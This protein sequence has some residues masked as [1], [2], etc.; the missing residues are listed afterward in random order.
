MGEIGT[1]SR[2]YIKF[3]EEVVTRYMQYEML[4]AT[5]R[6]DIMYMFIYEK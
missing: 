3:R 1:S 5:S 4:E 6:V 2:N